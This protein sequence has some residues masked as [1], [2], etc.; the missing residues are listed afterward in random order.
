MNPTTT[1]YKMKKL[2]I[3]LAVLSGLA[4][5]GLALS[6]LLVNYATV[7]TVSQ[8]AGPEHAPAYTALAVVC[9]V[10]TVA[11]LACREKAKMQSTNKAAQSAKS[12]PVSR[13]FLFSSSCLRSKF[14]NGGKI[15]KN[16]TRSVFPKFLV[17]R[18]QL[19]RPFVHTQ[20]N[21]A[22]G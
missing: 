19:Y 13:F 11:A 1:K 3:L 7:S 2:Y 22:S 9:L 15:G 20:Y 8:A 4:C 21:I 12:V 16:G 6:R 10:L 17:I 14:K 5:V 18:F